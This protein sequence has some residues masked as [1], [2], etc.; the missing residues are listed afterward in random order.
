MALTKKRKEEL[1]DSYAERLGRCEVTIWADYRGLKVEN[2]QALRAQ[3]RRANAET[4][5]VKNSLMRLALDRHELPID[6]QFMEGP[7]AIVFVYDEIPSAARAAVDFARE[8]EQAFKI[9]GGV[10]GGKL[11]SASRVGDLANLP[12]REV[13]L[14]RVAGGMN[15]PISGLVLTLSAVMRGLLNVL[16]A[17]RDQLEGAAG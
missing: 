10:V 17:H 1:V 13:L 4:M 6:E 9:K 8:N 16:N 14:A 5:V 15:A 7:N 12:T 11:V 2:F 3:L